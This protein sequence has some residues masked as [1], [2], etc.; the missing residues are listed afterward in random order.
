MFWKPKQGLFS[1]S[2][3]PTKQTKNMQVEKIKHSSTTF[4]FHHSPLCNR[5]VKR[6][7]YTFYSCF[8]QIQSLPIF[9]MTNLRFFHHTVT[10]LCNNTFRIMPVFARKNSS[11]FYTAGETTTFNRH[12]FSA[13]SNISTVW[14]IFKGAW[15]QLCCKLTDRWWRHSGNVNQ[16]VMPFAPVKVRPMCWHASRRHNHASKV[17]GSD[18]SLLELIVN[19]FVASADRARGMVGQLISSCWRAGK[20]AKDWMS[21]KQ[22][23]KQHQTNQHPTP[24]NKQTKNP[25]R[26]PAT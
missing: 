21:K 17:Q 26:H 4:S 8:C 22:K 14:W 12:A 15:L 3:T 7:C 6:K 18:M 20:C 13:A 23:P 2:F 25:E 9:H 5:M 10:I 24:T 11:Q 16:A 19:F 1:V